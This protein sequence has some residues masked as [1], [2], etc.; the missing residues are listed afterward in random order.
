MTEDQPRRV[1]QMMFQFVFRRDWIG[2]WS[3]D[4]VADYRMPDQIAVNSYLVRASRQGLDFDQRVSVKPAD[5]AVESLGRFAAQAFPHD[6]PMRPDFRIAA[7]G[8]VDLARI[9]FDAPADQSQVKFLHTAFAEMFR[10]GAV[11]ARG[12][13]DNHH[14]GRVAVETMDDARANRCAAALPKMIGQSVRQRARFFCI[15]RMREQS[16]RFVDG[17][18]LLVLDE[19]VERDWLG[20]RR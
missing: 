5:D 10:E 9:T 8:R 12:L 20:R 11:R 18:D 6:A 3:I 14:S 2:R 4:W 16:G 13:G 19:N 1:Q 7:D 17:D 15:R